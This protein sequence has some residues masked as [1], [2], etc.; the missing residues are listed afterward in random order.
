MPSEL[1]ELI[2]FLQVNPP[3]NSFVAVQVYDQIKLKVA[4]LLTKE[5]SR[6]ERKEVL[7]VLFGVRDSG[8]SRLPL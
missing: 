8:I 1:V 5:L 4:D 6:E 2:E 3:A 7:R